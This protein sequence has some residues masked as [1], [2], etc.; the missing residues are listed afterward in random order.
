MGFEPMTSVILVQ[1]STNWGSWP[2]W[3]GLIGQLVEHCT[4]ITEVMG[5]NPGQA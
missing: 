5:L 3:V 4:G 2:L 1:C